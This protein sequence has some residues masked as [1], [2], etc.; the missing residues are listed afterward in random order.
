MNRNRSLV[1]ALAIALGVISG[2]AGAQ[3]ASQPAKPPAARQKAAAAE[4][5]APAEVKLELEPKAVEILKEAS[6]KLASARTLSFTAVETFETLS[7][8]GEPLVFANKFEVV[9]QRP[10]KLRVILAGDGPASD[11][12]YD[13]KTMTAFAPSEGLVA[14]AD[15]P[16]TV[17]AALE[18]AYDSAAIYFPFTDLIVAD[19]Y[20]D[21]APGLVQAYYIGQSHLVGGT[22]T[23]I[24]ACA[25]NGV[26]MQIW[27]GTEDKLVRGVHAVYLDDPLRLRHNLIL[28][29]WKLD[30]EVPAGTF[31]SAEAAGAKRI[32]FANPNPKPSP[33]A[34]PPAKAKPPETP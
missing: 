23:D 1:C 29:D 12:Y 14:V 7:R 27:I 4:K 13:G 24:I 5:P 28:S 15:A 9:L 3:T 18:A 32:P 26:F 6:R 19:P 2:T 34:K 10:D 25:G 17:D 31:T 22:T 20:G 30:A 16:P 11:F 8:Q 21:M 33:G